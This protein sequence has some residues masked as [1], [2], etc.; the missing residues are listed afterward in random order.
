MKPEN[1]Y[2]IVVISILSSQFTIIK[3]DI[4]NRYFYFVQWITGQ[5]NL[6]T[7]NK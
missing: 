7:P 6:L 1:R 2:L 3:Y 4:K 5:S